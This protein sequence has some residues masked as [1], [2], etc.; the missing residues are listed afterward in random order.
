M[1]VF[2][3]ILANGVAEPPYLHRTRDTGFTAVYRTRKSTIKPSSCQPQD[4]ANF[5]KENYSNLEFFKDSMKN[6]NSPVL[7]F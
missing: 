3:E 5:C 2:S 4:R 1:S 7:Q 6:F